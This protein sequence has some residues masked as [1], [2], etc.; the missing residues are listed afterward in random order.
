M[1]RFAGSE[2]VIVSE[3]RRQPNG[4]ERSTKL[5]NATDLEGIFYTCQDNNKSRKEL[6]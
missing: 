3:E 6:G 4:V 5:R 1:G 2:P